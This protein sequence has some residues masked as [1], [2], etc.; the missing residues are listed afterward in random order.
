GGL[1]RHNPTGGAFQT[2]RYDPTR[3]DRL[4][5]PTVQCAFEMEDGRIWLGT[6]GR[7][8]DVLDRERGVVE[9]FLPDPSAPGALHD[10]QVLSIARTKDGTVWVATQQAGLHRYLGPGKGFRLIESAPKR[11]RQLFG[12][13]DGSLVI[14]TENGIYALDPKTESSAPLLPDDGRPFAFSVWSIVEDADRNLWVGSPRGLL[15]RS[16]G[17]A[18]FHRLEPPPPPATALSQQGVTCLLLDRKGRLWVATNAGIER[19]VRVESGRGFFE[20]LPNVTGSTMRMLEDTNGRLWTE[21]YVIDLERHE[22]HEFGRAD[23]VD[24]GNPPEI[25]KAAATRD[26]LLLLGA[27]A[28][29][30]VIDPARF[31]RWSYEPPLVLTELRVGGAAR[32]PASIADGLRLTPGIKGFSVALSALDYSAPE[33]NLYGYRLDGYDEKWT[34]L[35]SAHRSIAFNNLAPGSYAL[36][37]RGSN[38]TGAFSSHEL[39]LPVTVVPAFWQTTEFRVAAALLLLGLAWQAYR[40]RLHFLKARQRELEALVAE[41]TSDLRASEQ[42]ALEAS[43][44]KTAFLANMSHELRTPLNAVLGFAQLLERDRRFA[45]EEALPIIHRSGEHLLGLI[46]DVLSI[47]KIETG[48]LTLAPRP[49]DLH[50]LIASVKSIVAP[51]AESK[52]LSLRVEVDAALPRFVV[53]D[54]GKL[55][56]VLINLLGNA[57]KFTQKGRVSL[58]VGWHDERASFAVSDTGPG[59][60]EE[61]RA[62]LFTPFGQT[63]SGRKAKEGTGLGLV[64]SRRIVQLMGGDIR[65]ESRAGE[66][67][68]FSFDIP[69]AVAEGE[70]RAAPAASRAR[71]V[72]LAPGSPDLRILVADDT[73]ENRL[74]LARLLSGVGLEVHEAANGAQA[75]EE[76][77]R[78]KPDLVFMDMRMPV[79]DGPEATRRIR[80]A[81]AGG[82]KRTRIVALTAGAFEH[83]RRLLLESGADSVMTKPFRVDHLFTVLGEELGV[84]WRMEDEAGRAATASPQTALPESLPGLDVKGGLARA[85]GNRALYEQ[86]V[87]RLAAALPG[88]LAGLRDAVARGD[89]AGAA[90]TLHA[91]KGKASTLGATRVAA[92]AAALEAAAKEAPALLDISPLDAAGEELLRA[93]EALSGTPAGRSAAATDGDAAL[94]PDAARGA[95]AILGRLEAQISSADLAAGKTV[96]E[97]KKALGGAAGSAVTELQGFIADL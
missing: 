52:G 87:G 44:A 11:L 17:Q 36:K 67:A 60:A 10:G 78:W 82:A 61:E 45:G 34:A 84:S 75:V 9:R 69:L 16:A 73:L 88:D 8:I 58:R 5:H 21:R 80:A 48:N 66:G 96:D 47:S 50:E 29:L 64:I 33:K 97:L 4:G 23:G 26:G 70:V 86:L 25:G 92:E 76:C 90:E 7:G 39:S 2:L 12:S 27:S 24:V 30:L 13:E 57:V 20:P 94:S 56:Q 74:L 65:V 49:F 22:A 35:D 91:L 71:V 93:F 32:P 83:E 68:T 6:G 59:I 28:G 81:E 1:Q 14:G 46:D 37:L 41:R 40:A 55:R 72:G 62:R 77:A 63:E 42:R 89:A 54:E 15:L 3:T 38:R 95:L 51:R 31:Q 19:L 79:L 53:A 43:E 18:A 85:G